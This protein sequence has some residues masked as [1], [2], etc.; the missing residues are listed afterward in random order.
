MKSPLRAKKEDILYILYKK[1][2]KEEIEW[3]RKNENQS[4]SRNRN[5]PL[6]QVNNNG[7]SL[8]LHFLSTPF[9]FFS[10]IHNI[11]LFLFPSFL[12][13]LSSKP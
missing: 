10:F 1:E 6:K 9:N 12:Q 7:G 4:E 8:S 3:N 5:P 2:I 11:W 13:F